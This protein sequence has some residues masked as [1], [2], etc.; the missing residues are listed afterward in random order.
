[1]STPT[2][3]RAVYA[4][5]VLAITEVFAELAADEAARSGEPQDRRAWVD[6][7]AMVE[8]AATRSR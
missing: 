1:M 2:V 6:A 8:A 3:D 5:R 7:E 4:A